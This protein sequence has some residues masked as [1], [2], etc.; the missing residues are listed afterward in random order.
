MTAQIVLNIDNQPGSMARVVAALRRFG[1]SL[2]KHH[3]QSTGNGLS[4][5][6]LNVDGR[7]SPRELIEKLDDVKGVRQVISVGP[8]GGDITF[9]SQPPASEESNQISGLVQNIVSSFP[10]VLSIIEN[11]ESALSKDKMRGALMKELGEKVGT[12]LMENDQALKGAA[13]IHEALQHAVVPVLLPI[14]DAEAM[15][16]EVRTSISIFTR[17]QSNTTD[18]VF[19]N[20]ASRCDFMTGLIQGMINAS[21]T[22]AKVKVEEHACRAVG[23]DYC[24]FRVVD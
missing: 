3:I 14:S 15:G 11:Y 7:F 12:K 18:L 6:I 23:D 10:R 9:R 22:L 4:R 24:V 16:S 13:T 20:A 17:R 19:G 2:G 8:M 21:P 5:L 1:L